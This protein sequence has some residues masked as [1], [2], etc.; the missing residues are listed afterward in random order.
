MLLFFL[1]L[2]ILGHAFLPRPGQARHSLAEWSVTN[3]KE[4]L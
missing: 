4:F 3:S 2:L 1:R